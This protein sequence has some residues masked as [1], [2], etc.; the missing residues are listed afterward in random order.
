MKR[1]T[2]SFVFGFVALASGAGARATS[3][4]MPC[5]YEPVALA[6]EHLEASGDPPPSGYTIREAKAGELKEG[7]VAR[8]DSD[9]KTIVVDVAQV[10]AAV[11]AHDEGAAAFVLTL[12]EI[13]WHEYHH[14]EDYGIPSTPPAA[15]YSNGICLHVALYADSIAHMKTT[16]GQVSQAGGDVQTLCALLEGSLHAHNSNL[17]EHNAKCDPDRDRLFGCEECE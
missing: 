3:T 10:G 7:E 16:I 5:R 2:R 11:E 13:L 4:I 9:G 6:K 17:P 15:G 8:T 1:T 12:S 14:T